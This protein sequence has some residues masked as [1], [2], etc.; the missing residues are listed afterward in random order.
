[1]KVSA[2]DAITQG[3]NPYYIQIYDYIKHMIE[4]SKWPAG[5]QLPKLDDLAGMFGVSRLTAR[6][7][8][9]LLVQEGYL[10]SSRGR[11]T[12]VRE[13]TKKPNLTIH[14]KTDWSSLAR[15]ITGTVTKIILEESGVTSLPEEQPPESLV[16]QYHHIIRMHSYHGERFALTDLYLDEAVFAL[17][18]DLFRNQPILTTLDQLDEVSIK[19]AKQVI[20][21]SQAGMN[22]AEYLGLALNDPVTDIRR[23]A[24][25]EEDKLIYFGM[26]MYRSNYIKFE[27]DL[28]SRKTKVVS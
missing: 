20:F 21:C 4:S 14:T 12:F 5:F 17:A 13:R 26:I 16:P 8:T 25:S 2:K 11:G 23:Y 1:M 27:I 18:P 3:N 7:A 15:T 22:G 6:Q 10:K 28:I 24:V 19:S 9:S